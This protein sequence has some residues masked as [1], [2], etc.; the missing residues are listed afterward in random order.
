MI[1]AIIFDMDGVLIDSEKQKAEAWRRVLQ[2]YCHNDGDQWYLQRIG[3]GRKELCK[4]AVRTFSLPV[5]PEVL[6]KQRKDAYLRIIDVRTEPIQPAISF[7]ETI[8]EEIKIA[9]ASSTEKDIILLQ[10]RRLG[11]EDCF[12]VIASG[13]DDVHKNKPYPH[14]YLHCAWDLRLSSDKC[15]VIEDTEVGVQAAKTAEMKCI[16]YRT[17]Y[18]ANQ[19]LSKADRIIDDFSEITIDDV[20]EL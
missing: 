15:V 8:P 6:S 13:A 10:L 14:I 4:E 3:A 17:Q 2:T 1:K 11:I 5:A 20:L 7:L 19:D 12:D 16:A 18:S 9:V